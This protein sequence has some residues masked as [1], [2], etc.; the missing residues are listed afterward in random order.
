MKYQDEPDVCP[1]CGDEYESIHAVSKDGDDTHYWSITHSYE[2][3]S[4]LFVDEH[5]MAER[6]DPP[7]SEQEPDY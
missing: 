7:A 6:E 1:K 5:C 4:E 2:T 3:D